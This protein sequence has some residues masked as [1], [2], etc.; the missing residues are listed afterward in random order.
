LLNEIKGFAADINFHPAPFAVNAFCCCLADLIEKL[1]FENTSKTFSKQMFEDT[2]MP[3]LSREKDMGRLPNIKKEYM[4]LMLRRST[5][6]EPIHE[7]IV[8]AETTPVPTP[9]PTPVASDK[10]PTMMMVVEED[11]PEVTPAA[12]RLLAPVAE[13]EK[14]EEVIAN[15][16]L[17]A[18]RAGIMKSRSDFHSQEFKILDTITLG[19]DVQTSKYS[20]NLESGQYVL[21]VT[22][23]TNELHRSEAA[24]AK[25][26]LYNGAVIEY[27]PEGILVDEHI[28]YL[29]PIAAVNN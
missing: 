17:H 26:K 27:S 13:E 10:Q 19:K 15:I 24:K 28:F 12:I 8:K 1:D 21:H 23:R 22:E 29:C 16:P 25:R 4:S 20:I 2:V 3:L 7:A 5:L 14:D 11:Q 6:Y 9:V 18:I